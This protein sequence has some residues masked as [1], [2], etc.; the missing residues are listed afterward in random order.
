MMLFFSLFPSF[1]NLIY[2][3]AL[4]ALVATPALGS[5]VAVRDEGRVAPPVLQATLLAA[6]AI[7]LASLLVF[8]LIY[9][10]PDGDIPGG[11]AIVVSMLIAS[12]SWAILPGVATIE[13]PRGTPPATHEESWSLKAGTPR[14][15]P[16]P[17][18]KPYART[19]TVASL[20][21][22]P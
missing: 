10:V 21:V 6:S 3:L 11:G 19:A 2:P 5:L 15:I 7:F 12:L 8:F 20:E 16:R 1:P 18:S 9:A 14:R 17:Q 13:I 22:P 4:T